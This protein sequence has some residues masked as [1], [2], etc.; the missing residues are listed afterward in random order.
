M[1]VAKDITFS[2]FIKNFASI[3]ISFVLKLGNSTKTSKEKWVVLRNSFSVFRQLRNQLSAN[4]FTD[5]SQQI[6]NHLC[7]DLMCF[8]NT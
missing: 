4:Y 7:I 2:V 1:L 8:S 5:T 3:G 6:M